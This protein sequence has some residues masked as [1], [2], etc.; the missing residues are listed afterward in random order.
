MFQKI[1]CEGL[2]W[3]LQTITGSAAAPD[4]VR[5]AGVLNSSQNIILGIGEF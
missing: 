1:K 2:D 3:S 4:D 5:G